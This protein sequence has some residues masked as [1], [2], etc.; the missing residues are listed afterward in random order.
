[1]SSPPK[2]ITSQEIY[3]INRICLITPGH[4]SSNPRLVKE[5]ITLTNAGYA[6]H[7][8]FTQYMDSLILQDQEILAENPTITYD[9]LIWTKDH[10]MKRGLSKTFQKLAFS[11]SLLIKRRLFL[12]SILVNRNFRW[13]LRKAIHAT[14]DLYI[15]HNLGALPVAV[16]AARRLGAYSSFDAEDFH[17][18][19]VSDSITS[20]EYQTTKLAEDLFIPQLNH[21][22]A[23][24]PM[25]A[26]A[27]AKLY[28]NKNLE[29][30]NNVFPEKLFCPPKEPSGDQMLR[31]FWFSQT[32]GKGRGIEDIIKAI[33]QI[34]NPLIS[35]S[36]LGNIDESNRSHFME[37]ANN[38]GLFDRQIIFITSVS[39]TEVFKV[40]NQHDIGLALERA[41]PLNRD[42]CL[43][44]KIF[45]YLGAGLAIIVTE[46]SAQ[47]AFIKQHPQTGTS[48]RI[49]DI[50]HLAMRL[51]HYYRDREA[52]MSA[53][54]AAYQLAKTT[55]NWELE[56][57]K[58]LRTIKEIQYLQQ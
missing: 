30:L 24:S 34:G 50:D 17:R 1:M 32:I 14:A 51:D 41:S 45:T 16:L 44:N 43:T 26:N 42:I 55:L 33:G 19:E 54:K 2:F 4:L 27:Y 36:L 7:I 57:K 18:Q 15:A 38:S 53:K 35:L 25:I 22:T 58:L 31:L 10:M 47:S 46:T 12:T 39:A 3:R 9:N 28:P 56:S 52:L 40:A 48:Y 49:G 21:F 20:K 5:A 6:V 13:Q 11:L 29:V 37:I 23:A 8:I